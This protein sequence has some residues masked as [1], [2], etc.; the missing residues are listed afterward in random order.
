MSARTSP[1]AMTAAPTWLARARRTTRGSARRRACGL[2]HPAPRSV[3]R[4]RCCAPR[5]S[6]GRCGDRGDRRDRRPAGPARRPRVARG[7]FG[8][9]G[10]L[11]PPV[12]VAR[13]SRRLRRGG[14]GAQRRG[15]G[16]LV[17]ASPRRSLAR[18]G[19]D[20]RTGR[21]CVRCAAGDLDLG[22]APVLHDRLGGDWGPWRCRAGVELDRAPWRLGGASTPEDAFG[23]PQRLATDASSVPKAAVGTDGTAV[24]LYSKQRVPRR[25]DDGLRLH[26]AVGAGGFVAQRSTSARAGGDGRRG[27]GDARRA[28]PR[29]LDR[30]GS[31]RACSLV[32]GAAR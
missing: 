29:G 6:S 23:P 13:A 25:A 27:D 4:A 7:A 19:V 21:R 31:H 30:R 12:A 2:P 10:R 26:W 5:A 15:R 8:V 20:P 1:W 3:R 28:R 17:P 32:G 18:G 9:R 22:A 24:V 14:H 11:R 16:H